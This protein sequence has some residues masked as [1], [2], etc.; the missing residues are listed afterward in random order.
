MTVRWSTFSAAAAALFLLAGCAG[1]GGGFSD[2][3]LTKTQVRPA[4][5]PGNFRFAHAG[6]TMPV[7]VHGEIGDFPSDEIGAALADVMTG[8]TPAG[9]TDFVGDQ[10]VGTDVSRLAVKAAPPI[11]MSANSLCAG[12]RLTERAD[13]REGEFRLLIAYCNRTRHLSSTVLTVR[14][15]PDAGAL[16]TDGFRQGARQVAVRLFPARNPDDRGR[17]MLE[18]GG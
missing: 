16:Q 13:A 5:D 14:Q 10:A 2:F 7:V 18:L 9:R 4:Y 11:D 15:T 17:R 3:V 1:G 6:R 8:F 12:E